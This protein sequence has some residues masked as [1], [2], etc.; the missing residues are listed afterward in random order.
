MFTSLIH[1]NKTTENKII[2]SHELK[3]GNGI[4]LFL[5]LSWGKENIVSI[6]EDHFLETL[7]GIE[8][9]KRD[10]DTDFSFV[11]ENYNRFI[12]NIDTEDL[13]GVD[14]VFA[15]LSDTYLIL[16]T[17]G[18]GEVLLIDEN[19]DISTLSTNSAKDLYFHAF[20]SG[21]IQPGSD[22]YLASSSIEN[23]LSEDIF[24]DCMTLESEEWKNT[25][26]RILEKEIQESIHVWLIRNEKITHS[27]NEVRWRK[28]SAILRNW[29]NQ[30]R[31]LYGWRISDFFQKIPHT[32]IN[33]K[34]SQAKY[35][36]LGFWVILLF[37]LVYSV[38]W[39]LFSLINSP[40][41][42]SKNSLIR[43]RE[44]IEQSQKLTTNPTN[45][46]KNI[47][48]AEE[49]LFWLRAKEQHMADTQ[50]LLWRIESLKK[51]VNDIQT[52]DLR[53][54]N[55]LVSFVGI[56]FSPVWVFETN[57]KIN[58][59]WKSN[60]I[61]GYVR[62]EKIANPTPYPPGE[63]TKDFAVGDDGNFFILTENNRIISPRRND[64]TYVTVTGQD[65][66]QKSDMLKSFNGN[67]YLASA[68][69]GQIYKHKPGINGFSAKAE[70]IYGQTAPIRD[71]GIDWGIYILLQDGKIA[72]YIA[73][74]ENR[75]ITL[76]KIPGEYDLGNDENTHMVVE[77][78]LSYIYIQSGK[79]IWIFSPDSKRFQDVT[80]W[81]YVAQLELSSDEEVKNISVPR[82]GII[83]ITTPTAVYELWFEVADGK[84]I[85]K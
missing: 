44:L 14:I 57:K 61:L 32:I 37:F 26:S 83:Y 20:S 50:E 56:D 12:Q 85:L 6:L 42:D 68:A 9:K 67:I 38:F 65:G 17:I 35:I 81:N 28:Q 79:R 78:N 34:N 15:V 72:R 45:F 59:I 18:N 62:W 11:S 53:K 21:N 75:N 69:S 60:A 10:I 40:A 55:P 23:K 54:M 13:E 2:R 64:I 52:V 70:I 76:N 48:E 73:G 82:D 63:T 84:I 16:S 8:W 30:V 46:T 77:W 43:A 22:V 41:A 36:F 27:E 24:Q 5:I 58:I 7:S 47:K 49:I 19:R 74:K 33:S 31:Q 3:P 1:Q 71:F 39:S 4:V 25:L 51:E 29:I 66:W 80:A